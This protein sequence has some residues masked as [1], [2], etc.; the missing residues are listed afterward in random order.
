MWPKDYSLNP[1]S[2]P[3]V[4]VYPCSLIQFETNQVYYAFF[5]TVVEAD[6]DVKGYSNS[7]KDIRQDLTHLDDEVD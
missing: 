7:H 1:W 5:S 6:E 2:L 3:A 4:R